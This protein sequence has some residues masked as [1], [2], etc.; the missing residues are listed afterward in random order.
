MQ[1]N[2]MDILIVYTV[3]LIVILGINL[4]IIVVTAR[5]ETKMRDRLVELLIEVNKICGKTKNCEGCVGYD[6]GVYCK[7]HLAADRLLAE[8]VIV[9]PCK[10][11]QTVYVIE[12]LWFGIWVEDEHKC[13]K[14]EHF[15]EGG[16]GDDPDCSLGKNCCYHIVEKEAGLRSLVDWITPN[17]FTKEI[18][19]GKTIF[20]T[21][22]EAEKALA[23]RKD[24]EI[25]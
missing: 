14:C 6:K 23:E 25:H 16:M 11:G 17:E 2:D 7:H 1:Q 12:P 21:R 24:D 10:V 19:W 22:S 15:Y 20:L 5:G 4:T 18:A 3:F 9:L 8:G 13:R